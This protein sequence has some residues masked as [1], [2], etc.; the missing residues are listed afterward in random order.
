MRQIAFLLFA[1]AMAAGE[2]GAALVL[3]D[4]DKDKGDDAEL[5]HLNHGSVEDLHF[6]KD[7]LNL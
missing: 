2:K 4:Y 7:T 6:D 5:D 1:A 3:E